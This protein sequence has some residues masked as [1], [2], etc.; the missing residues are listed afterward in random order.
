MGATLERQNHK[1]GVALVKAFEKILKQGR[2]HPNRLQTDRGKEFYNRTF[3]RW[4]DEQDI[5]HFSTEG[6]AKASVVERFNRTLKERLYRYF[7]AANTL[8]FDD[9]LPELVQG[10]S[11]TRHR[12]IG[13]APQDVTWD[14]EEAV[15]KRLYGQH[16]KA[17][18]PK[19]KFN[20]GDRVR[21]NKIHRTFEKGY[22]PGWTEEVFVV[23]RVIPG[24]CPPIR[25]TNGMTPP[26]KARFM[27]RIYKKSRCPTC[28]ASKRY[29]SD[30]KIDGWSSGKGGPTSTIVGLL[31]VP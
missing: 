10:Y 30:K 3:Q 11:A 23:H 31:V 9:V 20:V 14:N 5:H 29:L 12:S 4:L 13:M 8:R 24:P 7:T 28:F 26:S 2:R 1:T 17:K 6:D 27:K 16:V 21:L 18:R 25:F 22:L 15:W 19:A